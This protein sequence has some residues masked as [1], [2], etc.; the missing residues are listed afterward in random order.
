MVRAALLH[1]G[2]GFTI[3]A[4]MLYNKGNPTDPSIWRWLTAHLDFLLLGWTMQFAM[5]VAFWIMPR[6]PGER[7]YGREWFV[8]LALILI[9]AG[10]LTVAASSW[11]GAAA[12]MMLLAGRS[13]E[14]LAAAAFVIHI[15]PRV[16]AL[17]VPIT[18]KE[19]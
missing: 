19:R 8:W 5:G 9:N 14:L 10:V 2:I 1:F 17:G 16:K 15:W 7:K 6:F 18:K 13:A 3:G 12:N 4:L 11:G